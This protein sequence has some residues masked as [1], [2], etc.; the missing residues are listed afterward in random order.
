MVTII[1]CSGKIKNFN[2]TSIEIIFHT[3]FLGFCIMLHSAGP[4]KGLALN[5]YNRYKT[6]N[7]IKV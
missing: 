5:D 7:L 3:S 2:S 4:L 6:N 1:D